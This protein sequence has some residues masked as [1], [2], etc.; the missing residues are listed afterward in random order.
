[1]VAIINLKAA[2]KTYLGLTLVIFLTKP[3]STS[4]VYIT[5][6]SG[7]SESSI[8]SPHPSTFGSF[9]TRCEFITLRYATG[10]TDAF[11]A[12]D[13][14]YNWSSRTYQDYIV[15]HLGF[16]PWMAHGVKGKGGKT[17]TDSDAKS[18][19]SAEKWIG[20]PIDQSPY[21]VLN[22]KWIY[23]IGD[24][25]M[26]QVWA[27]FAAPIK[28][29]KFERNAKE[30]SRKSCDKQ[31]HRKRHT[32]WTYD[33]E[34][35]RGPCGA[36]EVQCHISG[37]G[38]GGLLT[39]DW[40]HFP[41]EDYDEWQWSPSGPWFK[42]FSGEGN[43]RPDLL[44]VQTGL[45]TCWHSI[46]SPDGRHHL[47]QS[48]DTMIQRHENDLW[49]LMKH[50]REAIDHGSKEKERND[51]TVIVL[52]SG[53]TGLGK[54]GLKADACIQRLNRIATD[55]AHAY[56]FAVLDRGEIERRLVYKSMF[57]AHRLLPVDVHLGQPA[58]TIVATALL[59]LYDCLIMFNLSRS[60]RPSE[61]TVVYP[62]RK[63][64]GHNT[65]WSLA[66]PLYAPPS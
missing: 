11:N 5:N 59:K 45:H 65:D 20:A 60:R 63:V 13:I 15:K 50:I 27:S 18:L 42:G 30:W 55:A 29:N 64:D 4:A 46:L 7:S 32:G 35:W 58:Q 49:K 47:T 21:A 62:L 17:L 34:G 39:Y 52:T 31:D 40:K 25:T 6:Y 36:N 54:D 8:A 41:F 16:A 2:S 3:H 33:E 10:L 1:M 26:R 48:N 24:S 19:H 14:N 53:A 38:D 61:A 43:R 22:N 57:T 37:Y 12:P 9:T 51:T 44:T 28:G 66:E 23:M 56:G